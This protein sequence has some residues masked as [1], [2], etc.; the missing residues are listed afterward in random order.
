MILKRNT[1]KTRSKGKREI[2][3]THVVPIDQTNERMADQKRSK[4]EKKQI[5]KK[6]TYR[7]YLLRFSF[8]LSVYV[9][10]MCDICLVSIS[11][12]AEWPSGGNA[13]VLLLGFDSFFSFFFWSLKFQSRNWS[14]TRY[15]WWLHDAV[16]CLHNVDDRSRVTVRRLWLFFAS[17][18]LGHNKH[19][20]KR[21]RQHNW[22]KTG[23]NGFARSFQ[24]LIVF[25][26]SRFSSG[27]SLRCLFVMHGAFLAWL[28]IP[29]YRSQWRA[30]W[31]LSA[32]LC[33]IV[34]SFV[35]NID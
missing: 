13:R 3:I 2:P 35:S 15:Y 16:V 14:I 29:I 28:F 1:M 12:L 7:L 34:K 32:R 27:F 8:R 31:D 26:I 25:I 21:I 24:F 23:M 10:W 17:L 6:R 33:Q 30:E 11:M 19:R 4:T 5:S 20:K 9:H 18:F 22:T